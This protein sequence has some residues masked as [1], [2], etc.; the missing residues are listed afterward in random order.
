MFDWEI[1]DVAELMFLLE[2]TKLNSFV[3]DRRIWKGDPSRVFSVSSYYLLLS[4][5][6]VAHF[7]IDFLWKSK[8]PSKV[9]FFFMGA[10]SR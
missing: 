4:Q 2:N 8:V 5:N 9:A 7:P 6:I 3:E 10:S 1:A